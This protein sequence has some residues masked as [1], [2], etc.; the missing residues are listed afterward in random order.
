MLPPSVQSELDDL[1][2]VLTS[3]PLLKAQAG[4]D[5]I[6]TDTVFRA[7]EAEDIAHF[8]AWLSGLESRRRIRLGLYFEDL[9]LYAIQHLSDYEL[10]AHDL[11]IFNGTQTLGAFDFIVSA[12]DG[13]I[14]HWEAAVKFFLQSE[15]TAD[16]NAWIGPNGR[17]SLHRKMTKMLGRQIHL[18]DRPEAQ[19]TLA[20]L[21]ILPPT[22]KRILSK[23]ILFQPYLNPDWP[24]AQAAHPEQPKGHWIRVMD[25]L[26]HLEETECTS[27]W[28]V[29]LRPDWM[30]CV[31]EQ[32]TEQLYT[33]AQLKG[34]LHGHTRAIM[35][36]EMHPHKSYFQ[37]VRRWFVI[38]ET[39]PQ[40]QLEH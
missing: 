19:K 11:Q 1:R 26:R 9:I 21:D 34:L 12:P 28:K 16:W 15:P 25:F 38:S 20:E 24:I 7:I 23:G 31:T 4:H 40:P 27:D 5:V 37:E 33:T 29:R 39:W 35:L 13:E 8:K 14:E 18:S 6:D 2:W 32:S 36:S 10:L 30:A 3:P 22:R 17:D